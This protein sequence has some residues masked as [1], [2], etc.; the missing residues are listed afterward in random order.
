MNFSEGERLA[1]SRFGV[2]WGVGEQKIF[3]GKLLLPIFAPPL[4]K[5]GIVL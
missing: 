5:A 1:G 3:G 2:F 4:G